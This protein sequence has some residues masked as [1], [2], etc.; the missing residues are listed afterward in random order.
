M[1]M[2]RAQALLIAVMLGVTGASQADA[3]PDAK[4]VDL[5]RDWEICGPFDA[6]GLDQFV[7]TNEAAISPATTNFAARTS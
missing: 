1:T 3:P 2:R 4:A 7:V 6:S 5:I